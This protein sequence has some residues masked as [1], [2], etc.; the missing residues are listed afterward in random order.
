VREGRL[1]RREVQLHESARGVVDEDEQDARWGSAF[2]R[3]V[4]AA[5]DLHGLAQ[6]GSAVARLVHLDR[7]WG[8]T[9]HYYCGPTNDQS[10]S[11]I[12]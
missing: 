4:V 10:T 7:L 6:T 2:E 1:C 12:M 3:G 9:R 5:I 8:Q 11:S